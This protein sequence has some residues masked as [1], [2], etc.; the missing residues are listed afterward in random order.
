[1][2]D[3]WFFSY[4]RSC[5]RTREREPKEEQKQGEEV[6]DNDHDLVYV[7]WVCMQ[8]MLHVSIIQ[9]ILFF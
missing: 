8:E 3:W 9:T 1:M 2:D 5:A 7:M 6:F 4:F